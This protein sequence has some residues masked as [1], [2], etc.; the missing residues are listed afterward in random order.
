[1]EMGLAASIS[2]VQHNH[3]RQEAQYR[4]MGM[5]KEKLE[6]EGSSIMRLIEK[7]E[8][9]SRQIESHRGQNLNIYA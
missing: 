5:I 9:I 4:V 2:A 3:L 6:N 8:E 7:Q 1:M